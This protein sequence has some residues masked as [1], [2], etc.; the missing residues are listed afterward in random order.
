MELITSGQVGSIVDEGG[1]QMIV[2]LALT[3]V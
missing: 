3:E 1:V 2:M